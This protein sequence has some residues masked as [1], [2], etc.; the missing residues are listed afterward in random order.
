MDKNQ[1]NMRTSKPN[2]LERINQS[3]RLQITVWTGVIIAVT[4]IALLA[5]TIVT[6]RQAAIKAAENEAMAVAE[7]NASRIRDELSTPI[8][9]A[10]TLADAFEGI[11]DPKNPIRLSRAQVNAMIKKVVEENPT[12]LA[13]YTLWEPNAFDGLDSL[14][15]GKEGYDETG[16]FI[17]YW[18]RRPD[19]SVTVEPLID[20]EVPGDGDWY[21]IPRQ[22]RRE[23]TNAPEIYPVAGVDTV[24]ATFTIPIVVNGQF[25]GITGVDAPIAFVQDIVDNV[26]LYN[27][28]AEAILLTD[29]GTLVAVHQSPEYVN[30]SAT[31]LFEDFAELQ[32]RIAAEETFVS[33]SPDGQYLRVFSPVDIGDVGSKWSFSLIIPFSAITAQATATALLEVVIGL[34]L[35]A[36][37]LYILWYLTGQIVQPILNLTAV[38]ES[39]QQGNLNV[40]AVVEAENETGT[41]AKAFNAMTARL[42]ELVSSLEE[43]IH[44]RT[45]NLELAAQVGRTLS[46]VRDLQELLTDAAEL[47]REQFDLYYVQ[48]YLLNP[49]KTQLVLRAGTGEAGRELLSQEHK[50]QLNLNSLNGRAALEKKSIIIADT[51]KSA[52]FRP[53]VLLPETR[54]EM[55][56]PLMVGNEV[57]G[58]L[59]MQSVHSN[60]LNEELLPAFEAMAGQLAITIQNANFL[61]QVEQA[62]VEVERQARSQVRADW[63]TYMDAV[64]KPEH[65][66]FVYEQ[67]RITPLS[68]PA[69]AQPASEN[70]LAVPIEV[71]G[72]ALGNLVIEL[73]EQADPVRGQALAEAVARQVS[74]HI[75]SLRL[76]E[77]AER[78]RQEAEEATR[79]I[80]REGWQE[81]LENKSTGQ[82]GYL[83]D[84]KEVK[85]LE[86]G[87]SPAENGVFTLPIKIR[88]ETVGKLAV[89][90]MDKHNTESMDLMLAVTDRLSAHI[91]SLRQFEENE[92]RRRE[93]ETLLR[94]L[95]VQKYALDQ[96]SI[97]AITDVSGKITYVNDKLVEI[98]KYPREE[99]LGQDHRLLNSGYHPKEFIRNLWVTIANG[100]V[101][102][103]EIRNRAKDGSLYWV[104][105]TI[106]PILNAAGKPERYLAIRT[107]I[108]Q[109]K[110]DEELMAKRA[111][112]LD[113]VA[114]IS[115]AAATILDTDEMLQRVVDLT[116]ERFNLYHT[117][118]YVMDDAGE[119]LVLTSGAGEVGREMVSQKRSISISNEH[120]LVARAA[121]TKEGVIANDVTAEPDFLP[122]PLLPET[123]SEM[124]VPM[125]VGNRLVGVFDVQANIVNRF[126]DEDVRIKTTLAAQVAVALENARTFTQAQ[127]QAQRESTLNVIN[128]KIQSATTVEAV[129][130]IAARELGHALG[131][132]MTIAQLSL[133]DNDSS[134]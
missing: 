24:M 2:F 3:L 80:T 27:N 47:I 97:V 128:Q 133:K 82:I 41:L 78:F 34:A 88:E 70:A 107:D 99:L 95:D 126:T 94:E 55:T 18:V 105:T 29:T 93:A 104:D 69:E 6:T 60:A 125:I 106:V 91:E 75:E 50:L 66:G 32:P 83:Y 13:S 130:Q 71:T 65:T 51:L 16:R 11:K 1:E 7:L 23:Y 86:N 72:E 101:W 5:Y 37:A 79:R 122:N 25:L 4:A 85:P 57:V 123:R 102:H 67:D 21:L 115:T 31:L 73:E 36:L 17:P 87:N 114:A 113:T 10:R 108:T 63:E 118:V 59:D 116:K 14:Y 109:R 61:A 52:T 129:L 96:H 131:A 19:G 40:T 77:S 112:E 48:V 42:R 15:A 53:N 117:H 58:V 132:P 30:Q 64:H 26:N 49:S 121:R 84:L 62:R 111:A 39:V 74:Q 110:L 124:A 100:K 98:S 8:S 76:L 46:Q 56:I 28:Q 22:T 127:R 119:N 43:R 35:L 12:F 92:K 38:A 120:S 9:T 89:Q 54:S 20:Y 103:G 44:A 90:G 81:Y 134:S 45:R 33:L 68:D